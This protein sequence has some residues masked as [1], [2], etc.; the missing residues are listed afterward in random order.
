MKKQK[1]LWIIWGVIVVVL[2][3]LLTTLGFMLNKKYKAY[4][5]LEDKLKESAEKYG[6]TEFI[7]RDG[8]SNYKIT[9]DELLETIYLD[10]LDI[11]NDTCTGYVTVKLD[12]VYEYKAYIKCGKYTT[13]NYDKYK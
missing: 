1:I 7:Y 6:N 11:E 4:Y 3:V 10:N 12:T 9:S 2:L 13:K 5:E 8:S